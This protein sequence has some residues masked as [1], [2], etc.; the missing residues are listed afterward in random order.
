MS[1]TASTNPATNTTV[2]KAGYK[3]GDITKGIVRSVTGKQKYEFGDITKAIDRKLKESGKHHS[4]TVNDPYV[5][6]DVTRELLRQLEDHR[7]GDRSVSRDAHGAMRSALASGLNMSTVAD[8]LPV[9]MLVQIIS[10]GLDDDGEGGTNATSTKK[11]AFN[12]I[13][14][15]ALDQRVKSAM[16][17]ND[18]DNNDSS[19]NSKGKV[20]VAVEAL[21]GEKGFS[22]GTVAR[23]VSSMAKSNDK[24]TK[25]QNNTVLIAL[26]DALAEW[27]DK[28]KT[29]TATT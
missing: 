21:T 2:T 20:R 11:S 16:N 19:N 9:K 29:N 17:D 22:V 23:V 4:K 15:E 7:N 18:A 6:G 1:A 27:D 13:L 12:D 28:R 24:N 5:F 3:F 26:A 8:K 25:T 10:A 14:G